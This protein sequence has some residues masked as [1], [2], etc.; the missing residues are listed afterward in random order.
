[1]LPIGSFARKQ[2]DFAR[3]N[4]IRLEIVYRRDFSKQLLPTLTLLLLLRESISA[5]RTRGCTHRDAKCLAF[6][7][8]FFVFIEITL[9]AV[10]S[11]KKKKEKRKNRL[12]QNSTEKEK[13]WK[14]M[15]HPNFRERRGENSSRCDT[16][17]DKK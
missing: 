15:K 6:L 9:T 8:F 14:T 13:N 10:I 4:R 1:M 7:Y 2:G 12:W 16:E 3:E 17:I 5:S 11:I